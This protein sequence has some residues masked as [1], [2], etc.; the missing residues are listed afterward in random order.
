MGLE[1]NNQSNI[2]FHLGLEKTGSTFYQNTI[3]KNLIGIKYHRKSKFKYFE[4]IIEKNPNGKHLFAFETDRELFNT[5]DK[6]AK[7]T[8]NAQIFII[9]R[10]QDS[11]LSSKYHYH[12]RKH[13]FL[14]LRSF[15]DLKNDTGP[16]KKEELYLKPKIDYLESKIQS[17]ILFLNYE[18]L[19]Q[20]AEKYVGRMLSFMGTE[21]NRSANIHKPRKKAFSLKQN[22]ILM[23][24]NK[25]YR[26][27]KANTGSKFW[28]RVHYK[29]REFLLHIISFIGQFV[30]SFMVSKEPIIDKGYLKEI[31]D[32]YQEDWEYALPKVNKV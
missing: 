1:K 5:V 20:D 6:V 26:Y 32:F 8:P 10:R 12:I 16:Q 11:W 30:P 27:K 19:K 13:G 3:F 29:Y 2:Y 31:K 21:L 14:S 25:F 4:K 24:F 23:S 22:R 15:F 7:Y 17:P 18:E 9:L 28:N